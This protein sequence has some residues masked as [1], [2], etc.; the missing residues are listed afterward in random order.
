M[1]EHPVPE[2]I[3]ARI[4]DVTVSFALLENTINM[5]ASFQLREGH[6][7]ANIITAELSFRGVRA[8][9]ANLYRE[10]HGDDD[11]DFPTLLALL[12]RAADLEQQRNIII[13]SLW[14]AGGDAVS[15]TRIKT[16][17]K[18]KAGLRFD[19]EAVTA[20]DL[21]ALADSILQLAHD[22]QDFLI[23]FMEARGTMN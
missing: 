16:T 14:A 3:L 20:N 17:A 9:V 10:R 1:L 21:K 7:V 8:L 15:V 6:R 23:S 12:R 11:P 22:I 4:G 18:E 19:F 2:P 13:H 5:L